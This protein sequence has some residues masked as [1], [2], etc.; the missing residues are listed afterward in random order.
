VPTE[1]KGALELRKALRQFAPDLAKETRKEIAGILKPIAKD[2]KGFVPSN[3][4]IISGWT[5]AKQ[6][7]AW[8]RVAYDA[9]LVKR[10]IG[11]KTSPSKPNAQGFVALAQIRNRSAAGAI[12]ETAGRKTSG[13]EFTPRFTSMTD[14]PS[15]RGRLIFKAWRN[16]NGKAVPAVIKAIETSADKLNKTAS[17]I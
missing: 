14:S 9:S 2:A 15:G 11:Y 12:Y 3:E 5:V 1:V 13:G 8:E 6:K 16:S 7:G 4:E 17:V 10:G